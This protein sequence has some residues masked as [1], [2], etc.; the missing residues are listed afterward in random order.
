MLALGAPDVVT[1]RPRGLG[2]GLEM[3]AETTMTMYVDSMVSALGV[4]IPL[5]GGSGGHDDNGTVVPP[6]VV[7]GT[8]EG[9]VHFM[10]FLQQSG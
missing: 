1:P 7:V 4:F 2:G 8:A 3:R 6:I 9:Q 10:R 5:A